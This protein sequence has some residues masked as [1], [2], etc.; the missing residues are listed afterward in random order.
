MLLFK[1][2][3]ISKNS[4]A[5]ATLARISSSQT[6]LALPKSAFGEHATNNDPSLKRLMKKR[7]KVCIG[8]FWQ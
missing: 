6:F 2:S 1:H 4:T 3:R 7:K 8:G 5:Y